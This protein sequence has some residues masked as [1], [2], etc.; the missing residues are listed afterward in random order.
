MHTVRRVDGEK[1]RAV[2][3]HKGREDGEKGRAVF[4]HK[5]RVVDE[6]CLHTRGE[7]TEG[8]VDER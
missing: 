4:A 2:F 5:G 3:A 8:R 7:W 6:V 1:G